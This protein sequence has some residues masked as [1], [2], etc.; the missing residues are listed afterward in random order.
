MLGRL[1]EWARD[2][3]TR[4]AVASAKEALDR[5]ALVAAAEEL[6]GRL[7]PGQVVASVLPSG[8]AFT[9][10]HLAC[11]EAGAVFLPLP[12]KAKAAELARAFAEVAPSVVLAAPEELESVAAA[13][14]APALV[15]ER[16]WGAG[17]PRGGAT[18]PAEAAMVQL[19]SGST[20]IP[21]AVVLSAA[22][23]EAALEANGEFLRRFEGRAVFSPMPQFHA[24]GGAVVLEHLLHGATVLVANRFVPGDDR[25][26]M[27]ASE[28][29]LLVGSPSYFRMLLRLKMLGGDSLPSLRAVSLGSAASDDALL[30]ALRETNAAISM[31]LRYG[32]SEAFGALTRLDVEAGDDLP[33][34]GL[35]GAALPGVILD[36]LPELSSGSAQELRVR[37]AAAALG[38]VVDGAVEAL[39]DDA[40]FL[41]TGDHA[42]LDPRGVHLRGRHSQ[43]IKRNGHRID[44]GE[45]EAALVAHPG[46]ADAVVV[47]LPDAL[48]GQRIVAMVEGEAPKKE[49]VAHCARLLSKHK[50][51]QEIVGVS[52]L[53][54][55]PSGKPDRAAARQALAKD[56]GGGANRV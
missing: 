12:R 18:L 39:V 55:T 31:H 53:P 43:F 2:D 25:K 37:S 23:V 16:G 3:P 46:I 52:E 14:D 5:R 38:R 19:T 1:R 33:P 6:A 20:G 28:C 40:G 7:A 47:G 42:A 24:M 26:R 48:A 30:R 56:S 41:P 45:I 9:S 32:L 50:L 17:T 54:R 44:P 11:F 29:A 10:A 13:T 49:L 15:W 21:K 4:V 8:P 27:Q 34:R 36:Q 51:P 22:N 35:V